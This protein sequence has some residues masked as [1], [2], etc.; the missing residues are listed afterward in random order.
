M[1]DHGSDHASRV[2]RV[3][4]PF[5]RLGAVPVLPLMIWLALVVAGPSL[6][7]AQTTLN[8]GSDAQSDNLGIFAAGG[9]ITNNSSLVIYSGAAYGNFGLGSGASFHNNGSFA[10]NHEYTGLSTSALATASSLA[11]SL[12]PNG[13]LQN[14]VISGTGSLVVYDLSTITQSLTLQGTANQVFV[15]NVSGNITLNG[16]SS[17]TLNGVNANNV[18]FN[19]G[20]SITT[21][22]SNNLY[23]TYLALSSSITLNAS[24]TVHGSLIGG[25]GITNYGSTAIYAQ[26]FNAD[27]VVTTTP[28]L[29]TIAMAGTAFLVLIGKAGFGWMKRRRRAM[30]SGP[31]SDMTP[32]A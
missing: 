7:S 10:Y 29:P 9:T 2:L 28:E 18:L 32:S 11:N 27:P 22:G 3:V 17:I 4:A 16:S 25:S 30:I 1:G 26:I 5:G 12:T 20:G 14:G 6:A 8:L 31:T 19:V 15:I 21:N 13:T 23:G 24:T